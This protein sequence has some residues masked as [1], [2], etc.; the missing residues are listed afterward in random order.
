MSKELII[1]MGAPA[2]GKSSYYKDQFSDTHV[3][4]NLDMLKT[5]NREKLLM[6]ACFETDQSLVIDN[7]N[8][9]KEDRLK[10]IA[11]AKECDFKIIGIY[12]EVEELN[13]LLVC[14][15]KRKLDA[16]VPDIAVVSIF[17]KLEKAE[18]S[19]GFDKI[20]TILN[21]QNRSFEIY[22]EDK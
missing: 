14:N 7:T 12:F 11:K 1:L 16:I 18:Y 17:N 9:T 20:Y 21:G 4:I 6:D 13:D 10:Y 8:P 3:R 2:S 22:E 15:R 5:R 19:E